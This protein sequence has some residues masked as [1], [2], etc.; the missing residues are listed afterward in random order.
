MLVVHNRYRSA[1]PSGE[2]RVVDDEIALLGEAGVDVDAYLRES[3]E[4]DGFGLAARAE[5]AL[6]PIWSREDAGALA[7]R[8]AVRRPDVVHLHNPYPLISPAAVW[9]ASRAGV[10]V[11]QTVHNYRHVC[12]A[13]TFFRDGAVCRDCAGRPVPWPAVAHGCYRGSRPQSAVMAAALTLHRPTW[14]RVQRFVAV[15]PYV[16]GQLGTTGIR[17]D[18]I[19]VKPNAVPDP[20]PPTAPGEGF[21]LA[22]RLEEEKGIRLLLDAWARSGLDGTVGLTVAG[23]GPLRPLVEAA[24]ARSRT[25]V[26][27]GPLPRDRVAGL[28]DGCRAVVVPSVWFEGLPTTILE[29]FARGR[30]VVA[31]T[32]GSIPDV[33]DADV[34]WL[35]A[36]EP[37]A[38][39]DALRA[40]AGADPAPR[41]AAARRRYEERYTPA[42]VRDQLL[43]LYDRVSTATRAH[44]GSP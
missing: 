42:I 17:P 5:L 27:A 7:R 20:G 11:V 1:L 22:A 14:R 23:D 9:V 19:E 21:V 41:A 16:A 35:A 8:I 32:M 40:A 29:A 13:G 44:R 34:G 28:L 36:P 31:T 12:A 2:N 6:R 3:D 38:L 43:D 4:I 26:A 33:V 37:A 10:P 39:A 25:L 30:P 24:A 18:R 15:S